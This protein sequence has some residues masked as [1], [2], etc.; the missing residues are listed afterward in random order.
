MIAY[1]M[2]LAERRY[3]MNVFR[4]AVCAIV[5][6]VSICLLSFGLG[7]LEDAGRVRSEQLRQSRFIARAIP[8]TPS[9]VVTDGSLARV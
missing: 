6:F 4:I 1:G 2:M 8:V 3:L 5:A 7:W 9:A